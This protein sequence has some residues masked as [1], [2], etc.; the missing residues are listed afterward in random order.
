[1]ILDHCFPVIRSDPST[2]LRGCVICVYA[3]QKMQNY[4]FQLK[5]EQFCE[6]L[7]LTNVYEIISLIFFQIDT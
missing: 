5:H 1:M 2:T 4:S 3:L 6:M 7:L